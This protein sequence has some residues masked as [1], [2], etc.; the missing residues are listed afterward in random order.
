MHMQLRRY[1]FEAVR[2]VLLLSQ[3][4][5]LVCTFSSNYGR[6]AYELMLA[7]ASETVP[8][9]GSVQGSVQTRPRTHPMAVSLDLP[10][11]AYP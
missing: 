3:A 10:W 7:G 5:V 4:R 6:L 2:G 8:L 11:F 9:L 1:T